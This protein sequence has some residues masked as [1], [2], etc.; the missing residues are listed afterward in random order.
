M[1]RAMQEM[2]E[3]ARHAVEGDYEEGGHAESFAAYLKTISRKPLLSPTEERR[4]TRKVRDGCPRAKDEL[5]Q[6]NLR[7]VVHAV[8]RYRGLG[9]DFEELVQEG[10]LGLIRAAEK[11]DPAKGYKFS[12]YATWWIRQAAGRAVGDKGRTVRLP[13]HYHEQLQTLRQAERR[14][15]AS[16]GREPTTEELAEERGLS[17]EKI[18]QMQRIRQSTASLDA[19][20]SGSVSAE[21]DDSTALVSLLA[22]EEASEEVSG[23]VMALGARSE[24]RPALAKLSEYERWVIERRYGL[25]GRPAATTLREIGEEAGVVYQHIGTVNQRAHKRLRAALAAQRS[26]E[27]VA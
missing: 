9:V 22:D 8:K 13:A 18:E 11:F 10:T 3:D 4:L 6:R 26:N 1:T 20:V 17:V 14:L 15:S 12:T 7:L 21:G 19:P 5:V 23:S 2:Y 25:D 16:L 27:Q 24:L